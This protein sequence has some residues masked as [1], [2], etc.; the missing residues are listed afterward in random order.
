MTQRTGTAALEREVADSSLTGDA[1]LHACLH[2]SCLDS[3]AGLHF[4]ETGLVIDKFLNLWHSWKL[5]QRVAVIAVAG[6]LILIVAS[7]IGS[8]VSGGSS[9]NNHSA[10][11]PQPSSTA[12]PTSTP[13]PQPT[14]KPTNAPKAPSTDT[15]RPAVTPPPSTATSVPAAP[16]QPPPYASCSASASVD[17]SSPVRNSEVAVTGV[18]V[19]SG[20]SPEGAP[21]HAVWH[22][23]S[24]DSTCYSTAGA[25]GRASCSRQIGRATIGLAVT[26]DV[27]FTLAG[28]TYHASTSFTPQ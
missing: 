5:W 3:F 25:D 16:T 10:S 12:R 4:R 23:S 20:A 6:F 1:I 2:P 15:P 13:E 28:Q 14:K 11:T 22:Y 27:T 7:S 8:A 17:N 9:N 26:I 21:M 24:T 19:C 18:L